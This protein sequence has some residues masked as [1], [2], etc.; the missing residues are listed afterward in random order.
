[1]RAAAG[2]APAPRP[3][4]PGVVLPSPPDVAAGR[5][6][7][8]LCTYNERENLPRLL[9]AVLAADDRLDVLVVD[10]A[11]PD[12]TGE[13]AEHH[14]ETEPRAA[15]LRRTERG[16]GSATLA[17][18]SA[19]AAG[20]YG[21]AVTMDADFSHHPRHLP[22]LLALLDTHDVAVGSRYVPGGRITGWPASRH[23][24][25]R[26]INVYTRLTLGLSQRD[27]SGAFR[28]Y[29]GALLRR[30]DLSA[31][32]SRGYSFFEEFLYRCAAAGATIAETPVHFE[33]RTAGVS[34][35]D[36]REAAT[37]L[38]LLARVGL[39][40]VMGRGNG[41]RRPSAP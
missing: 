11:S 27:C 33:N 1:M 9:P 40:R 17:G 29:R 37:A 20:G 16:L 5:V 4:A 30:T 14:A 15:A 32:R 28:A 38:W 21:A 12:G 3:V 7:V 26:A 13:W 22:A 25:S 2:V 36:A 8:V 19:A 6:L 23:L 39:E 24:M 10:D 34:S 41:G 18:L 35:L 31:V